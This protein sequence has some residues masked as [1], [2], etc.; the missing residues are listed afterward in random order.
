MEVYTHILHKHSHL[1]AAQHNC[2]PP[3]LVAE[4][5]YWAV[6]LCLAQRHVE[7]GCWHIHPTLQQLQVSPHSH[8]FTPLMAKRKVLSCSLQTQCAKSHKPV[9][10]KRA[11]GKKLKLQKASGQHKEWPC[12]QLH[13]TRCLER[14]PELRLLP[15][16]SPLWSDW[17]WHISLWNVNG[18]GMGLLL[19]FMWFWCYI[20]LL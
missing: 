15:R 6:C 14:R 16:T 13:L 3:L 10:L 20:L 19:I 8:F 2:D 4:Q 11:A 7:V 1:R 18:R 17:F 9:G 12:S 5:V